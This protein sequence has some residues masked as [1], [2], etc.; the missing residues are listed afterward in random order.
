MKRWDEFSLF[1]VIAVL[2][3]GIFVWYQVLFLKP[4][5]RPEVHFLDVGQGDAELIVLPNNVKV[6]TDAG[7]DFAAASDGDGDRNLIIGKK[8]FVTPSDGATHT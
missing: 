6:M 3:L 4:A 1:I 2:A 7:P 8:R 5:T